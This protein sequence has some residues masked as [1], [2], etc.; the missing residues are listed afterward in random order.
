MAVEEAAAMALVIPRRI[1]P[2]SQY[3]TLGLRGEGLLVMILAAGNTLNI[4][5]IIMDPVLVEGSTLN[6]IIMVSALVEGGTVDM[7]IITVR[8]LTDMVVVDGKGG[9]TEGKIE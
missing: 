4:L 3:R 1:L 6:I 7:S 9:G 2:Q 8:S 5:I